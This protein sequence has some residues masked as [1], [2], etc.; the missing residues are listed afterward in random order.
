[1]L[2]R[3]TRVLLAGVIA[4]TGVGIYW[5]AMP[6]ITAQKFVTT[7]SNEDFASADSMFDNPEDQ[8]LLRQFNHEDSWTFR[9]RANIEPI[10]VSQ[11]I[12]GTRVIAVELAYGKPGRV[13]VREWKM[14]AGQAGIST[15]TES[16]ISFGG[17]AIASP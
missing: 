16:W 13:Q 3:K 8:F 4:G 7:I 2:Q 6:S 17:M 11:L 9:A 14:K 15:P 5:I 1:M 12:Y 10:S